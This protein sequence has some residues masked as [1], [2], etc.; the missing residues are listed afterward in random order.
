MRSRE[1]V[2][3]LLFNSQNQLLL[4]KISDPKVADPTKPWLRSPFWVTLGGKIEQGE[5][6]MTAAGRE[7]AEETGLHDVVIGPVVWFGEQ[8]SH[9]TGE[10]T[11]L[12]ETFVIARTGDMRLTDEQWTIEER[13]AIVEMRWWPIDELE[14]TSETILPSVL[15][16]LIR[17]VSRGDRAAGPHV[18]SLTAPPHQ[19]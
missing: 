6:L 19:L 12:K 9:S 5:D 7:I 13:K 16:K 10:A 3:V 14:L 17:R 1:T 11:L 4:M 15:V 8:V 18:I 2:R